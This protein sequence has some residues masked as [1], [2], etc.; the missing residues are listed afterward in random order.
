MLTQRWLQGLDSPSIKFEDVETNRLFG[1][2][3]IAS[4]SEYV[5]MKLHSIIGYDL[6]QKKM[7]GTVIDHGPY[8]AS[9]IGEYD[10]ESK[11]IHWMAKARDTTGKP[12][13]Q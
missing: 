4:D 3:W 5:G 9:M 11:T 12:M 10:R 13:L 6:D 7:V 2:Y 1:E 8:S